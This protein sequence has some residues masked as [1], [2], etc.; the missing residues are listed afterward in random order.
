MQSTAGEGERRNDVW[1]A[2][3]RVTSGASAPRMRIGWLLLFAWLTLVPAGIVQA[4]PNA[5]WDIVHGQCVPN[6]EHHGRPEPCALVELRTGEARGYAVLKDLVGATQFLL[7][8]TARI[9]GIESRYS[10]A[11]IAFQSSSLTRTALERRPVISKGS[12]ASAVSSS[13]R[14]SFCRASLAFRLFMGAIVRF[15]VRVRKIYWHSTI[16]S[17]NLDTHP[18]SSLE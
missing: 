10:V 9:P 8:A 13:K 15:S 14:Y 18:S 6:E 2:S 4:D 1:W 12:C 16:P 17:A 11:W 7:I 5:L 3:G